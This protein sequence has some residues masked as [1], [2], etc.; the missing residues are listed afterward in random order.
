MA[1][2]STPMPGTG[3]GC[4]LFFQVSHYIGDIYCFS[5]FQHS[6]TR[7]VGSATVESWLLL[8]PYSN[9]WDPC[10]SSRLDALPMLH[11]ALFAYFRVDFCLACFCSFSSQLLLKTSLTAFLYTGLLGVHLI[12]CNVEG[13]LYLPRTSRIWEVQQFD[14]GSV[15]TSCL[16]TIS[17]SKE[18]SHL[19]MKERD[20]LLSINYKFY[21]TVGRFR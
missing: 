18:F 7:Q 6:L 5:I 16:Y 12:T 1:L 17:L 9:V 2:L 14:D 4:T 19:M 20:A 10:C 15:T 8:L 21:P 3:W 13:R 11:S